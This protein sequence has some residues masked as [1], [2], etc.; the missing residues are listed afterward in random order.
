MADENGLIGIGVSYDMAWQ[1]RNGG[2]SS[3]TG[4]GAAMGETTGKVL[5]YATRS[6]LCRVCDNASVM[7]QKPRKHDCRKKHVGSSKSMEPDV[8]VDLFQRA[9]HSGV[10]FSIYTGDD[11]TTTQSHI[12]EKVPYEVEKQSD[13]I[14]TKRSLISKLYALK[15]NQKF[16]GCSVLSVKVIGYLGNCFGYCVAQNKGNAESLQANTRNIVPHAFGKHGNCNES[17]CRYKKDPV[18]YKHNELPFGKDLHGDALEKALTEI[19]YDYSTD[20]VVK[21]LAPGGNSQRNEALNSVVGSKNPKI[22]HYGGSESN[23]YRVACG[24][25]QTNEGYSYVCQTLQEINIE[26]GQHC[27]D[28]SEAMNEKSLR[29]KVRKSSIDYKRRRANLYRRKI[30][31]NARK[32]AKEGTTYKTGVGL[33]L[34][35]S[36]QNTP[37]NL[38]KLTEDVT[39]SM[40]EEYEKLVPPFVKRPIQ[41][42]VT[43]NTSASRPPLLQGKQRSA[44]FHW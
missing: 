41:P 18:N 44:N 6:K 7:G 29:D 40:L 4:H 19:F 34:D 10:K 16:P 42:K 12:R 23:D 35:P 21:K 39:H 31:S 3:S 27:I 15:S 28:H 22:R 43:Y 25:S 30:N 1:R 32:E 13:T 8:A 17:W 11:D 20:I 33:N 38:L 24:V 37:T 5:D 2:Y 36:C 9:T 26:P 14:H